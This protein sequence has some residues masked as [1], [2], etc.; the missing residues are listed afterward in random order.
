IA[1][2]PTLQPKA[3]PL[4]YRSWSWLQM[5]G[6]LRP[7]VTLSRARGEL[8]AIETESIRTHTTG[9]NLAQFDIDLRQE[10]IRVESGERGFSRGRRALGPALGVLMAAVVLVVLIVCANVANLMLVRG[11]ARGREMTVRMTL[12]AGRARLMRQL[13]TE[14]LLLAS[15]G[16]LLGLFAAGGGSRLLLS[17]GG[18]ARAA[19][20][21]DVSPD[22]RVLAFTAGI[23]MLAALLFGLAPAAR[24]TR[25]EIATTLR[26]QGR[27]LM[28]VQTRLGRFAAGK[29][30]VVVQIALSAVLLIGA[31]LLIRTMQRI[32][33]AD[34]GFD[35]DHV[36]VAHV[37]AQKSGYEGQRTFALMRELTDRLRGVPSVIGT[38]V[39]MHG[40]FSGG[41]GGMHANVPG[42]TAAT[43]ADLEVGYDAIGPDYFRTIGTRILAGR[44]FDARD[45]EAAARVAI[46]NRTTANAYF[47]GADP[48]G[49]VIG[50]K[51]DKT[52]PPSTIVGVVDDIQDRSVRDLAGRRV[53]FPIFQ[54]DVQA[55]FVI[56]VRVAGDA[57]R[58]IASIREALLARDRNLIFEIQPV[59]DLVADSV[60]EDRL[61]TRVTTFFSVVALLLAALGLYGVTAYATSQRTGEFG[62][63]IALGAEPQSV[64]RMIV[65]E[66]SKL[67]ALG[68]AVGIPGGLLATRLIRGQ[69]FNVS[70]IDPPSLAL[71]IAMLA[72]M[73]L[74]ASYIPARR[75]AR[76]APL[77][78]LR[79]E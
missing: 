22:A 29:A 5:M 52:N 49:R 15:A 78:A 10:P 47:G 30:L 4:T 74:L 65:S 69:L 13:L 19:I 60:A 3:T 44:D 33:E 48:I 50:E 31:G 79:V 9:D 16:G 77:E 14:S 20:P 37:D 59:N 58:S 36:V 12:G 68:L 39:T 2:E 25:V 6:R 43:L 54:Q 70:S 67:A 66:G 76:I 18:T 56:V 8:A 51:E 42:F 21:L 73:A 46:I 53:F 40:L 32:F 61:T 24:A 75:A 72:G 27:T 28:G 1:I 63:R 35:R 45:S 7:G 38:S 23:T 64:T 26:A 11:V 34:L 71:A 55:G 41:W 62:L 17:V 57:A